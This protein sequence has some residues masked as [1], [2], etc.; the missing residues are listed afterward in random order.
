MYF[1]YSYESDGS[2]FLLMIIQLLFTYSKVCMFCVYMKPLDLVK[3]T[4]SSFNVKSSLSALEFRTLSN[5]NS[6]EGSCNCPIC[7][8][9][10]IHVAGMC[11]YSCLT[12]LPSQHS[13]TQSPLLTYFYSSICFG[14]SFSVTL[15]RPAMQIHY[16]YNS[17]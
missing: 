15:S 8:K 5:A 16:S 9:M 10:V 14:Q 2:S 6:G 1:K 12:L 7:R 4:V 11:V 13:R 3:K 17:H